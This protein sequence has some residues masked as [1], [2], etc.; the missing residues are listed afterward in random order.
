M[1]IPA[2]KN[3]WVKL[4]ILQ[5]V[6]EVFFRLAISTRKLDTAHFQ[7]FYHLNMVWSTNSYYLPPESQISVVSHS[8]AWVLLSKTH[9]HHILE[10]TI[11]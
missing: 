9:K 8:Y 7:I 4:S 3:S 1:C 2:R 5:I 11:Y 10:S 6:N